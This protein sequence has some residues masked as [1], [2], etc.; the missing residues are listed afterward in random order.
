M[1]LPSTIGLRGNT[2]G[3]LASRLSSKLHLGII[4]PHFRNNRILKDQVIATGMQL[5]A[6]SAL[7]PLIGEI[8]GL[9]FGL[10]FAPFTELLFI[11]LAAGLISG[12]LM[13]V[14]SLGITFLSFRKGWDPDNVSAP[15]I[16]SSGD[17][18]TIPILFF[19]AW[20]SQQVELVWIRWISIVIVVLIAISILILLI[21]YRKEVRDILIGMFPIALVAI[22]ISTFAGLVLGAAFDSYLKGT[23]F[24]LLVPAFNGQG[25]SLGSIL[26]SRLSSASYLGQD[27]LTLFPNGTGRRSSATLW[28]IS[29]VV[30]TFM[31]LVASGL[32]LA[33]GI[34]IP[35]YL[36]LTAIVLMGATLITF[37]SSSI[38]YYVAYVA[39]KL[40]L[41]PDNVVI[42]VL[43]AVM[44]VVGSGSLI[45][46]ILLI[47]A[48][49]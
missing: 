23:I 22:I 15:I 24:L 2:F 6:L 25:G 3:A 28:I 46:S 7:I 49:L 36:K 39:T 11:S 27:R 30:F 5:M 35:D 31:G 8:I 45:M 47:G 44:D 26:G 17:I 18:L 37:M 33:A 1:I 43:T 16:A 48:V 38:A 29:L 10:K 20:I 4:D 13:M 21:R 14:I 34:E 19:A 12:L 41:D 42:P 40:G 9:I 32:G